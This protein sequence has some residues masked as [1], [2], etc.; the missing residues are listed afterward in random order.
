MKF[1]YT[2]YHIHTNYSHDIKENGP[3]F[4][5][6]I[7]IAEEKCI[8]ICYLDHYELY[9]IENDPTYPFYNGKISNYLEE[10]D[11]LKEEYG[12]FILCGL[13]VDYYPDREEELWGFMDEYGKDLDFVGGSVHEF[14][15]EYP[16]TTKRLLQELLNKKKTSEVIETY[17]KTM[18]MMVESRIFSNVCHIDTIFRY[19]NEKDIS[20][21]QK[22]ESYQERI[23]NLGR[24]CIENNINIEYNLSGNRF[25]IGRPFPSFEVMKVL[26]EDGANFFVGSDSHS[27]DYFESQILNV[28][29]SY[30]TLGR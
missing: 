4:K 15:Y 13:E 12:D 16:V 9:Y 21:P 19:I 5:D 14:V 24:K 26:I 11:D 23:I 1:K 20:P 29:K 17:F 30:Q 27:L 2:D 28:K 3:Q 10:L 25:S 7:T 22:I 18:E 6:Y 8:N